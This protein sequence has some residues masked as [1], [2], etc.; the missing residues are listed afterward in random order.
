MCEVRFREK[1]TKKQK[2]TKY[3]GQQRKK[4]TM[5]TPFGVD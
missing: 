5:M 2:K 1:T 4:W 3:S